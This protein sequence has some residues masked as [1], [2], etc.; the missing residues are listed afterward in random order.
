ME[1]NLT[2]KYQ[3]KDVEVYIEN[4]LLD[5]LT[6]YI[7][8]EKRYFI[9]TDEN[10]KELYL[11]RLQK[12]LKNSIVYVL[13]PAEE[14]KNI[15]ESLKIITNMLSKNISKNDCIIA[16]GGGVITDIGGFVASIYKRGIKYIN[17][18]TTLLAQVDSSLGGKCGVNFLV[19]NQYYKNQV[20][21]I[22]HPDLILVDPLVLKTLKKAD[23]LSG[24]GEV[25]KYGLCF[26]RELFE[27]LFTDFLIEDVIFKCLK[28]KAD[29]TSR[30]EFEN[31]IRMTLNFGHTI[32]HAIESYT[33]FLIPHGT[34]VAIGML[35]EVSDELIINKLQTLYNKLGIIYNLNFNKSDL[36]KYIEKDKKITDQEINLPIL[37]K[38]GQTKLIKIKTNDFL[39]GI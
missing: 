38:I 10:V 26:D 1:K 15:E 36:I 2:V 25:V 20:G 22:Y 35:Y 9:L 6:K 19:N 14:S 17:I 32:A 4:G 8:K 16:L 37:I 31:D 33:N 39:R 18:P 30:D 21:T 27:E 13:K 34:S 3:S 23:Y 12:Q 7:D 5:N 24:L 11:D 29:I 28:I